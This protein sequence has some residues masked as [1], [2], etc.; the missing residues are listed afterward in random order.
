MKRKLNKPEVRSIYLQMGYWPAVKYNLDF[1]K[2]PDRT[3]NWFYR[4]GHLVSEVEHYVEDLGWC[5][6]YMLGYNDGRTGLHV[7]PEDA[8][9]DHRKRALVLHP[10][11]AA[12][13]PYGVLTVGLMA[14]YRL[15]AEGWLEGHGVARS[16]TRGLSARLWEASPAG[17]ADV[18]D[19][20]LGLCDMPFTMAC[21]LALW[22]T[23]DSDTQF[24]MH[25][26]NVL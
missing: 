11:V 6:G 1:A 24:W 8:I 17:Y 21:A 9:A 19:A 23:R 22:L 15:W 4:Q 7:G 13:D 12:R 3:R 5:L 10:D 26:P 18:R 16:R 14:Q 25:S 2:E 20:L